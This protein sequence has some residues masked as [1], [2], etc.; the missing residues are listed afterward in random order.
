M[1]GSKTKQEKLNNTLYFLLTLLNNNNIKDWF[2]GY[3]TLLGIIRNNSCID[4]DDDVDIICNINNYDLIKDLLS[5][6]E[7]IFEYGYG[8]NNSRKIL[9]TKQTKKYVSIDFYMAEINDNGNFRDDW[10]RVVWSNCYID[11]KKLIEY[12][13]KDIILY[14]PNNYEQKLINRYGENWKIP[15][16]NKGPTP[17]KKIL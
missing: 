12:V 15:Q 16:N 1:S 8:I 17:R 10:E 13:W 2:I 4:G 7:F 11:N 5:K 6:N 3:G 14:L 9:K